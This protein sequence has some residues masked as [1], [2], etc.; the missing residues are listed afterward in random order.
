MC[1]AFLIFGCIIAESQEDWI[2]FY[3]DITA[4]SLYILI[5]P[6]LTM[7]HISGLA[8]EV[9]IHSTIVSLPEILNILYRY[10]YDLCH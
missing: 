3:T 7:E 10:I 4:R 8:K 9:F 5:L 1:I 6:G 2:G